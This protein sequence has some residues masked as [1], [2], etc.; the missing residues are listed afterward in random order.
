MRI[1]D[2]I[3]TF[4]ELIA[5]YSIVQAV[6]HGTDNQQAI[7]HKYTS[8]AERDY[9]EELATK[10]ILK[11]ISGGQ[12]RAT[13]RLSITKQGPAKR[14]Q[15]Q[16][17]K[18]HAKVRTYIPTNFWREYHSPGLPRFLQTVRNT[19]HEYQDVLLVLQDCVDHLHDDLTSHEPV[20]APAPP[21][22][23][24]TPYIELMWQAI[25]EFKI[26]GENQ[27]IKE[28]LVEWF[29]T[30]EI[31]GA[32]VARATA[33]YLASFVRLPSSRTGGN[34]PWKVKA[35]QDQHVD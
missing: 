22:E 14:W 33:E 24:S 6:A 3:P 8:Y 7:G 32:K 20:Q 11:L 18:H 13:G 35:K 23:Y 21:S 34:R 27:P 2:Q 29:M 25:D 5:Y 17:F 9:A 16:K 1:K 31:E 28:T 10:K 26:S 4:P 12:I 30:Q 15:G 19:E